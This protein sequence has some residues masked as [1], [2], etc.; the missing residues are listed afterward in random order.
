MRSFSASSLQVL[1][2]CAIDQTLHKQYDGSQLRL[3]VEFSVVAFCQLSTTMSSTELKTLLKPP[4]RTESQKKATE[5]INVQFH[6]FED[7]KALDASVVESERRQSIL[8]SN[9]WSYLLHPRRRTDIPHLA[10]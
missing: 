7:L 4:V 3:R 2:I 10:L 9:V 1:C 5:A 6:S 8:K